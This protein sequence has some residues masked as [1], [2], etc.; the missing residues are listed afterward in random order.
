MEDR[1]GFTLIE[2]LVSIS[3]LALMIVAAFHFFSGAMD[4]HRRL[5]EKYLLL[6]Q[7][8]QFIDSFDSGEWAGVEDGGVFRFEWQAFPLHAP[9]R[10]SGGGMETRMREGLQLRLVHLEVIEKDRDKT[11]LTLDFLTNVQAAVRR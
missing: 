5:S 7:A 9:R 2:V 1:R 8:R 3:V 6:Q 11:S 10:M 4:N